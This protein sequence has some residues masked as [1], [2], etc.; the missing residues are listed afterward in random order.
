MLIATDIESLYTNVPILAVID[1][2]IDL[3]IQFN[4]DTYGISI[5]DFR[6]LLF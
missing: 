6:K 4:I 3:C 5:E 2:I 1:S